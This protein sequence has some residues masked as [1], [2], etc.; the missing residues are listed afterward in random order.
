M[1]SI[2]VLFIG[3]IVGKAGRLAVGSLVRD[4]R[5][6][7]H[8]DLIIAN[9]ENAAGGMGITPDIARELFSTGIDILTS[10]N[11]I[12]QKKEIIEYLQQEKKLLRPLNFPSDT[13][14]YGSCLV[15]TAAGYSVAVVNL[16]GRV[17]MDTYSC[18]FR[19]IEQEIERLHPLTQNIIVDFHAEATSEKMA[20]GWYVDGK[21]SAVLGTHTHVQT[22]DER[23]LPQGTAYITDVGMTGSMDGVIG[24][25]K[26]LALQKFL[27]YL[28]VRFETSTANPQLNGVMV[29][30]DPQNGRAIE[31]H[32]IQRK[33]PSS[34]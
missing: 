19:A 17:F 11:H 6:E 22:A 14:G 28:P 3:D 1:N 24:V 16:L 5:V 23:I 8:L 7:H 25:K 2:T 12:W 33:L 4:I 34:E 13:P 30:I 26:E 29:R 20:L 21:V 31:I 9:G 27:T 18:P 32:R 15:K 10:G